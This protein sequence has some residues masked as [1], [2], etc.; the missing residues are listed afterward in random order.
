MRPR[1]TRIVSLVSVAAFLAAAVAACSSA[2]TAPSAAIP[3]TVTD[4]WARP[5]AASGTGAAYM[6][7]ATAGAADDA[8]LGASSPVAGSVELH[9]TMTDASGMT[10]MSPIP[11][12]DIPAGGSVTLAPGGYHLMMMGLSKALEV[13]STVEVDLEFEHAGRVVVQVPVKQG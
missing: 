11:R 5:A 4:A 12:L 8:L 9:Q 13:G 2:A 7:I 6:T 3:P 1:A 10:G